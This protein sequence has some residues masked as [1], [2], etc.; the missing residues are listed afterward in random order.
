[1]LFRSQNVYGA[2]R[3][4]AYVLLEAKRVAF[5][6]VSGGYGTRTLTFWLLTE[7]GAVYQRTIT[8]VPGALRHTDART[9]SGGDDALPLALQWSISMYGGADG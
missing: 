9:Q 4:D 3:S 8:V 2:T 6:P 5:E 7:A 1:M